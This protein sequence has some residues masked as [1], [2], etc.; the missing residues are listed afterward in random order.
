MPDLMRQAR[1]DSKP[2]KGKVKDGEN[3]QLSC[4]ADMLAFSSIKRKMVQLV[5]VP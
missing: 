5:M 1:L 2:L 4:I 3:Q